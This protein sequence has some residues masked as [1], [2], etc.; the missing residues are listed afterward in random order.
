MVL[1]PTGVTLT[2]SQDDTVRIAVI[3]A[4]SVAQQMHLPFLAELRDRFTVVGVCDVSASLA[5]RAAAPFGAVATTDRRRLMDLAPDAVLI[6]VNAPSE[7]LTVEALESGA[8]V[9][10]EKPM[11]WSP[12]QAERIESA[13]ERTGRRLLVGYMK[14]YDPGYLLAERI[15]GEMGE[16]RG[17]IVRCV[18]GPNELYI[19]DVAQVAAADDLSA[20]LRAETMELMRAR[21]K[22]SF[23]EL[24]M[25]LSRAYG[26]LLGISCHELSVLRGLLGA[27]LEV[28]SA[29]VWDEGRWLFATLR[30][31]TCSISYTLGRVATRTFDEVFEFYSEDDAL[32]LSFPSPFLKHAPTLVTR[33]R[34]ME[35][36]SVEERSIASYE[37]AFRRELEHFHDCVTGRAAP[38]TPAADARGDAE[39]LTAI[40]RAARDGVAQ[41]LS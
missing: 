1:D 22:E 28:T 6:A 37:E 31:P 23:G 12:A 16:V 2:P 38:R 10:V 8:H 13:V 25:E 34:D 26:L 21:V 24:S 5:E 36:A 32:S 27:P 41:A 29:Q 39:I 20:T 11:A 4:G 35:G 9:F 15:M 7:D 30:Y 33:R 19:D 3:G 18:A 14:R 17:G 40:I